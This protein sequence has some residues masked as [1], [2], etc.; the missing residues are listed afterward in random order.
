ML[1]TLLTLLLPYRTTPQELEFHSKFVLGAYE[2]YYA[3]LSATGLRDRRVLAQLKRSTA[4]SM[5]MLFWRRPSLWVKVR[6]FHSQIL[7]LKKS[8]I[9]LDE[10]PEFLE[11]P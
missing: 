6:R 1:F 9:P 10:V 8:V 11:T 7:Q 4:Y 3:H 2:G 5:S